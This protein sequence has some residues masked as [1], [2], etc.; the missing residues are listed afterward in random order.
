ML[1]Q[2]SSLKG[3]CGRV[4]VRAPLCWVRACLSLCVAVSHLLVESVFVCLSG[5]V[6]VGVSV[7]LSGCLSQCLVLLVSVDLLVLLSSLYCCVFATHL[8]G[9]REEG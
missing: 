4:S 3:N 6:I 5:I 7:C 8:L 2:I 9:K 1:D